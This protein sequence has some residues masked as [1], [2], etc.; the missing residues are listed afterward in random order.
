MARISKSGISNGGTIDASHI[1]RIIEALDGTGSADIYATGSFTGSF[2]G[3]GS[4]L[5]N[6]TASSATSASFAT[7]AS[8][9]TGTVAS[10]S[11][12]TTASFLTGTIESASFASTASRAVSASF[13]TT[14]SYIKTAQTASY[15]LNAV[16]A[17][18][19]NSINN[20][21]PY[22]SIS[23][24]TATTTGSQKINVQS[25]VTSTDTNSAGMP[26]T[27][28]VIETTLAAS[29]IDDPASISSTEGYSNRML[30]TFQEVGGVIFQV[31]STTAISSSTFL[32]HQPGCN[33]R[34]T[35][36]A[37][38]PGGIWTTYTLALQVTGST[39]Y[40]GSWVATSRITQITGE[41]NFA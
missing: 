26:P 10:A 38:G 18:Y 22:T 29:F 7:T 17:S 15:V 36:V 37:S 2:I 12:A 21:S 41:S 4:G 23:Y 30:A 31:G 35:S 25:F 24:G 9:L 40:T 19:A 1:T 8:F 13:A 3:N 5:T 27:T 11:F 6:V 33:F 34:I 20:L 39:L 14:S 28:Y 16:S 32:S